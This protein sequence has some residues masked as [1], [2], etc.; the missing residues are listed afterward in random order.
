VDNGGLGTETATLFAEG[1]LDY[2]PRRP[3]G[4]G[5]AESTTIGGLDERIQACLA[6]MPARYRAIYR[7]AMSG[8][9]RKAAIT[10]AC[11]ECVGWE[12]EGVRRCTSP[13]C[14]LYPYRPYR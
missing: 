4:N 13:A 11:L 9:S 2:A 7:Q 12:R 3:R 14:P 8:R 10:A 5:D 6:S 1:T